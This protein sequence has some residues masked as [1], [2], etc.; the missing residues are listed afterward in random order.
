MS[1]DYVA[2]KAELDGAH[3]VTGAYNADDQ[4]A[5]DELNLFNI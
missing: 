1:I 2:L 3:P 4:L 5:A